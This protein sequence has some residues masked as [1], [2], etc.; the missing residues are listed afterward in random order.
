MTTACPPQW[1]VPRGMVGLHSS[2]AAE[3]LVR[4]DDRE[5][6]RNEVALC[7]TRE[8]SSSALMARSCRSTRLSPGIWRAQRCA[9]S[10]AGV[11]KAGPPVVLARRLRVTSLIRLGCAMS[12]GGARH[13]RLRGQ[14]GVCRPSSDANEVLRGELPSSSGRA[15]LVVQQ[16]GADEHPEKEELLELITVNETVKAAATAFTADVYVTPIKQ[17]EPPSRPWSGCRAAMSR[18]SSIALRRRPRRIRR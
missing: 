14:P 1:S 10:I 7:S 16:P 3:S 11:A 13:A 6:R 18:T 5:V 9:M 17:A 15:G 2:L 4:I 8:R 12:G